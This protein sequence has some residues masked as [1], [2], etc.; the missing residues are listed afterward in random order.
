MLSM[1]KTEEVNLLLLSYNYTFYE[2][3]TS[4]KKNTFRQKVAK[5]FENKIAQKY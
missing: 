1:K 2:W 4:F 5:G 3:S